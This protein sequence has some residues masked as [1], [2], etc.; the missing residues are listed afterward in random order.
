MGIKRINEVSQI[1]LIRTDYFLICITDL[2]I[3][4]ELKI[5]L[6]K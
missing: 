5:A 2:L 1:A 4:G 6:N 3:L